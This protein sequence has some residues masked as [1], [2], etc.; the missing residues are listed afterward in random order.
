MAFFYEPLGDGAYRSTDETVGPWG[1]DSQHGGPPAALVGGVLESC[2]PREGMRLA[3]VT[4]EILGPVPVAE[5]QVRA[6]VARP[7]R[8]V[9]L[10]EAVVAAGG[11]DVLRATGWRIAAEQGR[12]VAVAGTDPVPPRPE[13]ETPFT[14]DGAGLFGYGRAVEWRFAT[15]AS[16]RPGPAAV[17]TRLRGEVV[18]GAEPSGWQRVLAVAD[19]GNGV[20]AE[21]PLRD[22]LFINPDLTVALVRPPVGEW[23]CLQAHTTI[24][25]D[26]IGL[27]QSVLS[28]DTGG[29]GRGLQTLLVAPR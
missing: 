23:V 1:P 13:G 3:R 21:L 19:S 14:F 9:E 6:R 20:S 15:G 22:W 17:W 28:D 8:R 7:G 26:G 11:R 24:A 12:A 18:A 27:A 5:L 29:L 4:V 25:G 2:E 10:L 16:D